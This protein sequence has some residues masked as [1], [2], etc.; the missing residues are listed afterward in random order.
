[1]GSVIAS[2]LPINYVISHCN[3]QVIDLIKLITIQKIR[4]LLEQNKI[5][6]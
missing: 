1:M 6:N 2:K 5:G 3:N 4:E